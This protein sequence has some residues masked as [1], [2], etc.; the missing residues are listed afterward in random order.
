[1]I[2]AEQALPTESVSRLRVAANN[3][4]LVSGLTHCFYRYPARFSPSFVATAIDAF[5]EPGDVVLDPYMGGGTTIVEAMVRGRRAIGSDLN[6]LAVFVA[7]AKT[8]RLTAH[9]KA[10]V[11][12]WAGDV[13]GLSYRLEIGESRTLICASRTRNLN[14]PR[15]RPTKK[16]IAM[17]LREVEQMRSDHAKQFARCVLLNVGQWALNNRRVAPTLQQIR[18]RVWSTAVEM[19]HALDETTARLQDLKHVHEPVLHHGT[20]ADLP[21]LQPLATG[22]KASLVVTSP[23]YPG[24]HILYHRWQVDGRRETPAPYWIADCLDG[25][26]SAFYNF[27]DRRQHEDAPYFHESLRTLR[28]IRSVLKCGGIMVQLISF[29]K[30]RT[31]LPKYLRNMELAGFREIRHAMR[32]ESATPFRRIWRPVPQRAWYAT[33]KGSTSSSR[34]L[35]LL[36]RAV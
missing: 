34:E 8:A 31:Q 23:P 22:T 35:V 29:A 7:R 36:H 3:R 14:L 18:E 17:A 10:L 32:N 11:L 28:A 16:F 27:G 21:G 13:L 9:E 19:L 26:G 2:S 12:D 6:S 4:S 24:I 33:L 25:A 30:P 15:A 1:M 5:S 20:A